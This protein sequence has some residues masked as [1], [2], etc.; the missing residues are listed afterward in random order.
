VA[1]Y[2]HANGTQPGQPGVNATASIGSYGYNSASSSQEIV[3]LGI[4][5]KF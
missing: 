1:A 2:Q 5:H 4:R 3:S